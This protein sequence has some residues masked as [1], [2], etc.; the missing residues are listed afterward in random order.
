MVRH[1]QRNKERSLGP[2]ERHGAIVVG[3]TRR[4]TGLLQEFFSLH[5]LSGGRVLPT[6]APVAGMRYQCHLN[7]QRQ[8]QTI[9]TTEDPITGWQPQAL[10]P[11]ER[12]K[13]GH[14]HA[15]YQGD[16]AQHKLRKETASI[17]TKNSLKPKKLLNPHK[18]CRNT[19]THSS[20]SLW[21][22]ILSPRLTEWTSLVA[23]RLKR[24]PPMRET[25][26]Q[27]LGREDPL[28]KKTAIHSSILAWR[29]PWTEKP[30]SLQSTGLQRVGHD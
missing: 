19:N 13:A 6:Q 2:P 8:A 23:Q 18:L 11:W 17:Q 21:Q 22:I 20:L 15:T 24:L 16:K 14:L 12:A 25:R 3:H 28:E 26:V 7:L 30:S 5:V 29:I 10:P 1:N 9:A 4:G 27:S